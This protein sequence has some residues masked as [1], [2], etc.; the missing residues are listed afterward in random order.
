[1]AFIRY[2]N[3][4][5]SNI[6]NSLG[7]GWTHQ[8]STNLLVE[9]GKITIQQSDGRGE[10]FINKNGLWYGDA[11]S[12][13]ALTQDAIGFTLVS[14]QGKT[15]RYNL[16]GQILSQT[17]V[18]GLQSTYSYNGN[19]LL[20]TVT[21]PFGHTIAFTYNIDNRITTMTTPGGEVYSYKY[22]NVGNLDKVIYPDYSAKQYHYENTSFIH[23]LTGITDENGDRYAT[24]GYNN[25]GKAILTQHAETD[26]NIPQEK[27]SLSYD[28][29]TQTTVTD[30]VGGIEVL[31][32][33]ENLGAKNL[34]SR[35]NQSDNKGFHYSYDANN[36]L[37]SKTDAE[38]K[39]TNYIYN[40]TNQRTK[41]IEAAGSSEERVTEFQYLSEQ[42][43]FPIT[44]TSASVAEGVRKQTLYDYNTNH[45][46]KSISNNGFQPDGT[47]SSQTTTFKY[48][49]LG[50][51][52]QIDGPLQGN[53]DITRLSYYNCNTG[54]EC[55]QI[56][57]IKNALG[58]ITRYNEYDDN[59][60]LLSMTNVN[61]VITQYQY[62]SRGQ[63]INLKQKS[64]QDQTRNND[65]EYDSVGQLIKATQ[66]N[67]Q[68]LIYQYDAAHNL[69]SISDNKGNQ[70]NYFYDA[71]GNLTQTE[72]IDAD[73]TLLTHIEQTYDQRNH[74]KSFNN[75]GNIN[76]LQYDAIG[77][78]TG[79]VDANQN[80]STKHSYDSLN[81]IQQTLDALG[82][83][84]TYQ[85]DSNDRLTK[86]KAPN[87]ATTHYIYDDFGNL[88]QE[89]SPDQG[90]TINHYD[91]ANNLIKRIDARGIATNYYYDLLNR[92][93]SIDYPGEDEDIHYTYDNCINGIG[94]L[95]QIEDQSGLTQYKYNGFGNLIEQLKIN[96]TRQNIIAYHYDADNHVSEIIYSNNQEVNYQRNTLGHTTEINTWLN[97]K[98]QNIAKNI[99]YRGDGLLTAMTYGNGLEEIRSYDGAGRLS[100]I[101][102]GDQLEHCYQYDNNGNILQQTT[103]Q[104]H[105]YSYDSID[106][107][108]ESNSGNNS[109]QFSYDENGNR[110]RQSNDSTSTDY[111]YKENSNQLEAI[112]EHNLQLDAVGNTLID[113]KGLYRFEYNQ[114]GRLAK[115]Y[116]INN[117]NLVAQYI[118]NAQ[119]QRSLKITNNNVTYYL[120]TPKG[121]LLTE[122]RKDKDI[123][124]L[125]QLLQ[126]QT[127]L[128]QAIFE[129]QTQLLDYE[130]TQQQ[131]RNLI[132]TTQQQQTVAETELITLRKNEHNQARRLTRYQH[133]INHLTARLNDFA[134]Q[135]YRV[136]IYQRWRDR[137]QRKRNKIESHLEDLQKD[138]SD[139]HYLI[140]GYTETITK[141]QL[142][143]E[144]LS[145]TT[146]QQT[147]TE[148]QTQL[149][150]IE[151]RIA[152]LNQNDEPIKTS[153]KNYLYANSQLIAIVDN[154]QL[155]YVHNDH[156]GTPQAIT[157]QNQKIVWQAVYDPFGKATIIT[158]TLENNIRFPGQYFD[159]ETG[160]HYNYYRYYDPNTGRY[161][162]SDPIGLAGGLNTYAYVGGNPLKYIDWYGLTPITGTGTPSAGPTG[163]SI[164]GGTVIRSPGE[165]FRNK[166]LSKIIEKLTNK[167]V[168]IDPPTGKFVPNPYGFF[169][170]AIFYSKNTAKCQT[171]SCDLDFD[172][173]DDNAFEAGSCKAGF[174]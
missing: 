142:L 92:I 118:Y 20:D 26:N 136:T 106:R 15:E 67:G 79:F 143:I 82:H 83:F 68:Q 129:T 110:L 25:N 48:N 9:T 96:D 114:Q 90:T 125:E 7:Y 42:L 1:L 111:Q 69:R 147:L 84:T 40:T 4:G 148:L 71:K 37:L 74:L 161:I 44:I 95:C 54:A 109:W 58:Q 11:D 135:P 52:I 124:Q 173:L 73:G 18:V 134:D 107:L 55:G 39:V 155:Y 57:Q 33:T 133:I 88:L 100:C 5:S 70:L 154:E 53:Q 41:I 50:Q 132:Q 2:Y 76:Q 123:T 149:T 141:T 127:Q 45:T 32:Y 165:Q 86:V 159:K 89:Q 157:D 62:N 60:R 49:S 163:G 34:L 46:I 80:P 31:T 56:S 102:V 115:V 131:Q 139:Q 172:G 91:N 138:I 126:Q 166:I 85:Y 112:D 93:I 35:I 120:Y 151:Q 140:S 128:Q 61:G 146:L 97:D 160:L 12:H 101:K 51:V 75:A 8:W 3:S 78:L 64:L 103:Q 152:G 169:A 174:N 168:K 167:V 14:N 156:L 98:N 117:Q 105:D 29:D 66:A 28:S 21:T 30:A 162:T 22:T 158:E 119:G 87:N 10:I 99:Q 16:N 6:N 77:K 81:R 94:H 24:Y 144:Q 145:S 108:L 170:M 72:N 113:P 150:N 121:Q 23:S 36:N 17:S 63:L 47:A 38:G 137:Y 65:Y 153:T 19:N 43:D 164:S 13:L 59:G 122:I 104:T 130:N 27:F 171:L 116:N